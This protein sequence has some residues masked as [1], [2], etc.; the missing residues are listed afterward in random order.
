M[1]IS[2][3]R[4]LI[5]ITVCAL[6]C[7][8][9]M[10]LYG[11]VFKQNQSHQ[12]SFGQSVFVLECS[13]FICCNQFPHLFLNWNTIWKIT[14]VNKGDSV[15]LFKFK[16]IYSIDAFVMNL[17]FHVQLSFVFYLFGFGFGFGIALSFTILVIS[18]EP[19]TNSIQLN[20]F[21]VIPFCA[22]NCCTWFPYHH[23]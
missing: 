22:F 21:Q 17:S 7:V 13:L 18:H 3:Y 19:N 5:K 1:I 14:C 12:F 16:I 6:V 10:H 20:S 8:W 23:H 4:P 2:C 9:Q 11:C 15:D